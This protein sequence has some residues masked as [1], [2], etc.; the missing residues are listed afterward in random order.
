MSLLYGRTENA[1][2]RSFAN[3]APARGVD[4]APRSSRGRN[5]GALSRKTLDKLDMRILDVLQRDVMIPV[6]DLAEKVLSSKS[7]VWRRI[8]QMVTEGVIRERVAIVDPRS[9][10]LNVLVFVRVRM[11]A[12]SRDVLPQFVKAIQNCPE[13]LECHSLLGEVDFL[14]KVVAPSLNDYEEF[15]TKK[16]SRIDGVREVISSVS[17]S[18]L[19]P[20]TQLPL[21]WLAS[22]NVGRSE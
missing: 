18:Q 11:D 7:V 12:H 6:A 15:F 16:L 13:V 8:Q 1:V 9:V 19:V 17:I 10:G 22:V 5:E 3:S 4:A 2:E 20:T 21:R 14:L